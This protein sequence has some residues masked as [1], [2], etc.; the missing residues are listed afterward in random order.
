MAWDATI[1]HTCAPTHLHASAINVRAAATPSEGRLKAQ[2]YADMTERFDFRP[3]AVETLGA[4]GNNAL[5]MIAS[6][7]G[8]IH[9]QTG[10]SGIRSRIFRR[11]SVAVQAGN[12]RRIVE[13]HSQVA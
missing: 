13:A 12:A 7:V 11:L 2:K 8:Y 9:T 4:F 10:E 5:D 3:F 6:L 1:T